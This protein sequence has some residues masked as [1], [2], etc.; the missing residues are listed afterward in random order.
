MER[1]TRL[2]ATYLETLW[3]V[4]GA[5]SARKI[6]APTPMDSKILRKNNTILIPFPQLHYN[7]AV[8]VNE[9]SYFDRQ[10]FLNERNLRNSPSFKPFGGRVNYCPGCF[11]AKQEMLV[12]VAWILNHFWI[13]VA[14]VDLQ[15]ENKCTPRLFPKLDEST[16]ALGVNAPVKGSDVY[17]GLW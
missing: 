12:F 2:D 14:T 1:C 15:D 5:L 3:I 16:P 7:K 4:N 17:V 8:F 10:R 11:L 6:V 13:N 9:P